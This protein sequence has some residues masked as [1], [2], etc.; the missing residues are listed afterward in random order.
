MRI[1]TANLIVGIL[2][3]VVMLVGDAFSLIFA[4][5]VA[6]GEALLFVIDSM[7][8]LSAT[9]TNYGAVPALVFTVLLGVTAVLVFI[10]SI[11]AFFTAGR[12]HFKTTLVFYIINCVL[13][14]FGIF[15][16]VYCAF[17]L[18]RVL[19]DLEYRKL[20]FVWP[21]ICGLFAIALIVL[22]VI[23]LRKI[24]EDR[25]FQ[26]MLENMRQGWY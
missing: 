4:I 13:S 22:S 21:I 19:F 20:F 6:F 8:P 16:E 26:D 10:F 5:T 2:S 7:D 12:L 9:N 15:V 24:W 11:V 17:W 25:N 3:A 23:S 1:K 14:A 18:N